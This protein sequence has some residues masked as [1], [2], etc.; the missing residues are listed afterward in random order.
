MSE[1]KEII[2]A[3]IRELEKE[4]SRAH[5]EHEAAER[6]IRELRERKWKLLE[7]KGELP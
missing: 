6:R 1:E 4:I 7:Q 2:D 3:Q 5:R